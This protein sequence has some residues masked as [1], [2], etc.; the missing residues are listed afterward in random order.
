MY[1]SSHLSAISLIK[2]VVYTFV[3]LSMITLPTY[4]VSITGPLSGDQALGCGNPNP[5]P[6]SSFFPAV[7]TYLL[8]FFALAVL[9]VFFV[10]IKDGTLAGFKSDEPVL[11]QIFSR[12]GSSLIYVIFGGFIIYGVG[13]LIIQALYTSDFAAPLQRVFNPQT[14]LG[15]ERAYAADGAGHLPNNLKVTSVWDLFILA[16]QLTMRWVFIPLLIAGWVWAG[17]MFVQARGNPEAIKKA[18][19][20]LL[21]CFVWTIVLMVALGFLV[22]LRDT[23][24]QIVT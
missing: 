4:A 20:R 12:A 21:Y 14:F 5:C 10:F 1:I 7:G 9:V 22:S 15:I 6:L 2:K 3:L 16:Y 8:A 23:F 18:K 11:K 17:F 13:W 24:Y 19:A